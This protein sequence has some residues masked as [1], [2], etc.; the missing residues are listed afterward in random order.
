M[1]KILTL[2]QLKRRGWTLPNKCYLCKGED[3][4]ASHILL[5]CP[6]AN[7]LCHLV[8]AMTG[9]QRVMPLSIKDALFSSRGAFVG[10]KR[11]KA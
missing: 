4:S 3:K 1:G 10:K 9:V 6:M 5:H 2:D 7:M 8:F 11:K